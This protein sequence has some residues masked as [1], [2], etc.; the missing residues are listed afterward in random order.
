MRK[1]ISLLAVAAMLA[2]GL[3]FGAMGAGEEGCLV[4]KIN[5]ERQGQGLGPLAVNS[6]L[7]AIA[8]RHSA[9]MSVAG[10]WYHNENLR[11][12]LPSGW[13]Y[14]GENVGW[15]TDCSYMHNFFINSPP[16]R[17]NILGA[18]FNYIGVGVVAD[19]SGKLWVTEVFMQGSPA[20]KNADGGSEQAAP[21]PAP[22][23]VSDEGAIQTKTPKPTGSP[24]AV[25]SQLKATAKA[26][27]A[28]P[29]GK[30]SKVR[31]QK[32]LRTLAYVDEIEKEPEREKPSDPKNEIIFKL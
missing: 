8:R 31:S 17:K 23:P 21:P 28:P 11:N 22:A 5:A 27:Q 19:S 25:P 10:R 13:K 6:D 12:E 29:A 26:S 3:Q 4:S 16:H 30:P 15:A 7:V 14:Q 32:T 20:M 2:L 18:A 9:E 24:S 1:S